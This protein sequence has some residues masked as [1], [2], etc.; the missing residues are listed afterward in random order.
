MLLERY[1]KVFHSTKAV[2]DIDQ[3]VKSIDLE[4]RTR[5]PERGLMS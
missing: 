3:N 4:G 2:L 1:N 5:C